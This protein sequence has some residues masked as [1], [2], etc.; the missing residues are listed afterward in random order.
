MH[1]GAAVAGLADQI[2]NEPVGNGGVKRRRLWQIA[3]QLDA[4]D[5]EAFVSALNDHTVPARSIIRALAKRDIHLS[6]SIISHYRTG[7]YGSTL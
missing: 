6:E 4:E 5:R 2:K 3:D 7:H 1:K